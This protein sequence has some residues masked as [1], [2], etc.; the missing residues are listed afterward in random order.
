MPL[1][2]IVRTYTMFGS[3]LMLVAICGLYGIAPW[4]DIPEASTFFTVQALAVRTGTITCPFE[5]E[6]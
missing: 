1:L 5:R 2:K 3:I 4:P 6:Y